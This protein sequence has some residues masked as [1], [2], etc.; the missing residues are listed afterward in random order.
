MLSKLASRYGRLAQDNSQL[1]NERLHP[2]QE[3]WETVLED[4]EQLVTR[5]K[6]FLTK[7][8]LYHTQRAEVDSSLDDLT[9]KVDKL[10]STRELQLSDRRGRLKVG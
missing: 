6:E 4:I 5:R 10:Q 8:S 9:H 2:L 1:V 7:C 3:K